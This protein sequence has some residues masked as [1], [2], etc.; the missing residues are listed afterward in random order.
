MAVYAIAAGLVLSAIGSIKE[1]Q[2]QAAV[3]KRNAQL[4]E[5]DAV[6]QQQTAEF[7][8]EL[9]EIERDNAKNLAKRNA[10][11]LE[12][13]AVAVE[14]ANLAE[15]KKKAY[16]QK[17]R[18]SKQTSLWGKSGVALAGTPIVIEAQSEYLD[19]IEQ[20]SMLDIGNIEAAK[21]R[22]RKNLTI[23]EGDIQAKRFE[24]EAFEL[25]RGGK[26]QAGRLQA[27]AGLDK[28]SAKA[29]KRAG[30]TRAAS[31]ILIGGGKLKASMEES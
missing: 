28:F 21:L 29:T 8:A 3:M 4:A 5:R 2:A 11:V 10:A 19:S 7:N 24:A 12:M 17:R 23:Y 22:N 6:I 18:R 16:E 9:A 1:S 26:I 15:R 30:F 13:E 14:K 31:T 25:R 20:A 27:Q